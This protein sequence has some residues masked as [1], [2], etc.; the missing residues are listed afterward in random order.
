MGLCDVSAED[1][2]LGGPPMELRTIPGFDGVVEAAALAPAR[3]SQWLRPI[4]Q[5]R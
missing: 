4:R 3:R 1:A 5:G 2:G